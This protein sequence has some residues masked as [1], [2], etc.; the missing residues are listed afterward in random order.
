MIRD[1][2]A[3]GLSNVVFLKA[4]PVS[5]KAAHII[6]RFLDNRKLGLLDNVSTAS[7]SAKSS[8]S[9]TL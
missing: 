2:A 3:T 1:A 8:S 9:V 7:S 5:C 6:M 4:V